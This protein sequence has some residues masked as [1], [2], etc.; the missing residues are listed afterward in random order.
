MR[1]FR[2]LLTVCPI[3]KILS[4]LS[5]RFEK[6]ASNLQKDVEEPHCLKNK[7][8]NFEKKV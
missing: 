7:T 2:L 4:L 5:I 8:R 3:E 6:V 1:G